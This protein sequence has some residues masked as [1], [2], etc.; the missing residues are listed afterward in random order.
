VASAEV[1][2]V[3]RGDIVLVRTGW[4]SVFLAERNGEAWTAGSP[5][6]SWRVAEWLHDRE[7]AAIACDNIAVEVS[8]LEVEGAASVPSSAS[9]RPDAEM[10][11]LAI[12]ARTGRSDGIYEPNCCAPLRVTGAVI[13]D[14]S[15][16]AEV[17]G[18][19]ARRRMRRTR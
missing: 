10:W 13:A 4:W 19:S 14:Q 9:D 2:T 17:A 7:C 16:G 11:N 8:A 1:V 12:S 5:G 18:H 3:G 6:V 15:V